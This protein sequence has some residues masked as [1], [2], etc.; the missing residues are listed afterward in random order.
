[1]HDFE[2]F[3]RLVAPGALRVDPRHGHDRVIAPAEP[4]DSASRGAVLVF[5]LDAYPD[6]GVGDPASPGGDRGV[7]LLLY[8]E[9]RSAGPHHRPLL[10]RRHLHDDRLRR[11]GPACAMAP[12]W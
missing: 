6:R 4:H 3:N 10:Q 5:D 8:L 1:M 9:G 2:T 7:G 12:G 11:R